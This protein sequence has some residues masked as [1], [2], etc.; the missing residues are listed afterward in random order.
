MHER[1]INH[2]QGSAIVLGCHGRSSVVFG[3]KPHKML[4][5][6]ASTMVA[7]IS[8]LG[9]FSS[10]EPVA[11]PSRTTENPGQNQDHILYILYVL[12]YFMS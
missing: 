2:C 9:S 11:T 3:H 10:S 8:V 6:L 7:I 5:T 1:G 12:R 4:K